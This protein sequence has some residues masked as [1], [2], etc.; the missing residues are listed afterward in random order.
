MIQPEMAKLDE[1]IQQYLKLKILNF[2]TVALFKNSVV[3][4]D[5]LFKL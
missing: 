5:T 2:L 4:E 3:E 1:C